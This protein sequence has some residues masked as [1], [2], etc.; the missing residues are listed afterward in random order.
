MLRDERRKKVFPFEGVIWK[1]W[2]KTNLA[3]FAKF[4]LVYVEFESNV[5]MR[6]LSLS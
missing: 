4:Y 6:Q 3:C 2:T 5:L 1:I